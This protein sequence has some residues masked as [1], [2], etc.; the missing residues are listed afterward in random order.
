MDIVINSSDEHNDYFVLTDDN[1]VKYFWHGRK[2]VELDPEKILL[3]IR[4]REYPDNPLES[5]DTL[6]TFEQWI[7]DGC[8]IPEVLD[9]E[10][11]VIR[12]AYVAERVPWT[13]TQPSKT[14]VIDGELLSEQTLQDLN[15]A[16]T[17]SGLKTV[18][19]IIFKG[20]S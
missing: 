19:R 4:R 7:A 15:N 10:G 6:E 18:L 12:S 1:A 20:R 16:T 14:R 5:F 17:I 2:G 9:D 8:N 13:G 11:N 3:L